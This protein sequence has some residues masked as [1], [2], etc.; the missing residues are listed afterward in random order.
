MIRIYL[1]VKKQYKCKSD[2]EI[3]GFDEYISGYDKIH[4]ALHEGRECIVVVR[5]RQI[6]EVL[7]EQGKYYA[8]AMSL[9]VFSA[10]EEFKNKFKINLP[11]YISEGDIIE[12]V[13]LQEVDFNS[14]EGFE[15]A[16]LRESFGTFFLGS[17]F[18][19]ERLA[20]ICK[21][22]DLKAI[23]DK[24]RIVL[25]KVFQKRFRD[26]KEQLKGEYEKYIFEQFINDF[27]SLRSDV[28]VYLLIKD[29]PKDFKEEMLGH[30]LCRCMDNFGVTGSYIPIDEK[31]EDDYRDRFKM[32]VGKKN[33]S[34]ETLIGWV[35]GCYE[36]ELEQILAAMGKDNASIDD[37]IDRIVIKFAPLFDKAPEAKLRITN[38]KPPVEL[39]KPGDDF[40]I[41]EWIKWA[42]GNYLPYHF[43]LEYNG[44]TDKNADEFATAFGDFIF[45]KYDEIINNYP[46]IMYKV[47][48]S[49]K[50]NL[51]ENEHTLFVILDNFN[52]KY[53]DFLTTCM[54]NERF[55]TEEVT[56]I[57]SM[58]PT[59]TAISKRAFFTGEAY[60]D[61]GDKYDKIVGNWAK[62]L[63][64]SMQ[65]LPNIGSLKSLDAFDKKVYFLNY[66]RLDEML[67]EDQ[68]SSAQR[69]E[70]RIQR[71]L[72]AL[73][74]EISRILKRF[75]REK[76]TNVYFIADHGSTQILPSQPNGID[77]KYYK[78]KAQESDYRFI[79]V[80]DEDYENTKTAIGNLCYALDKE[81]YG[82]ANSF[83]IARGYN[84]FIKNDLRGYVHGGIT[85]EEAIVPFVRFSYDMD[86]C[87]DPE[88]TLVNDNLRFAVKL[89]LTFLIKNY[90]EFPVE[91]V[92]L[93]IQNGNIKYSKADAVSIMGLESA[94]VDIPDAR[95]T[96]SMDKKN[97]EIMIVTVNY[98]ANGRK[99]SYQVAITMSIKSAQS[100]GMDLSDLI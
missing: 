36:F 70:V 24:N 54:N 97:N 74:S 50:D 61:N 85:P 25:R 7:K 17:T 3:N 14:G 10:T 60:N 96:K 19:F 34:V 53:L 40:D 38:I 99:H 15:N 48:P 21:S 82:T 31:V 57:L 39:E 11:D 68:G 65:Y 91:N 62:S 8:H 76:D 2:I 79:E 28:A 86:M 52:Y 51:I 75:G 83:F 26:Y 37:Y 30:D 56:P 22:V 4:S 13:S 58:I 45:E 43:W 41:E 1:D 33:P 67:H 23:N 88:I 66:L 69:I 73:V 49:V 77:P 18:P 64:A 98:S 59:E 32:Y 6:Y 95:I 93:I 71:E 87:K 80:V 78:D 5:N 100:S 84:R 46:G 94:T 47:L 55:V 63:D 72:E 16:V 42:V 89:K 27:E 12:D 44:K 92:E 29:Y 9:D 90:N 35:S 20:A 81:R